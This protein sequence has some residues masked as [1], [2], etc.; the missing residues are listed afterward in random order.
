MD[1]SVHKNVEV[2]H[3]SDEKLPENTESE[4]ELSIETWFR[5]PWLM[6]FENKYVLIQFVIFT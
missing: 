3:E 4:G 5:I 6:I 1:F 2:V